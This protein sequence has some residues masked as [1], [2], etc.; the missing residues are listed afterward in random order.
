MM[1]D[2]TKNNRSTQQIIYHTNEIQTNDYRGECLPKLIKNNIKIY[3]MNINGIDLR[4]GYHTMLKLC[5]SLN[6]VSADI[7]G[8]TETN[9]H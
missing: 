4:N 5:H 8:L 3:Y 6:K 7:I 9:F 1:K 2:K